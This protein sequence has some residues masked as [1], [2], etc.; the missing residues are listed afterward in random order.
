MSSGVP[1][2]S[3]SQRLLATLLFREVLDADAP[4]K[5]FSQSS[6][7]AVKSYFCA[8]GKRAINQ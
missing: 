3:Y 8:D 2:V 5:A 7:P 6:V 4:A 1:N